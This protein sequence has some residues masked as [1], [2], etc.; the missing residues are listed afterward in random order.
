MPPLRKIAARKGPAPLRLRRF[1]DALSAV[2]RERAAVD[3]ELFAA[4]RT[5]AADAESLVA[6]HVDELIALAAT[7]IRS[8]VE[9]G[10]FRKVDAVATARAV[11]MATSRFHHPAHAAEWAATDVDSGYEDVW[12]LLM[13][14]LTPAKT[15][16]RRSG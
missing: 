5:L 15:G 2:K 14:G 13:S 6:A 9:E 3:P 11:L 8:G 4:Y 1:I 12:K 10:T 7:V 16:V